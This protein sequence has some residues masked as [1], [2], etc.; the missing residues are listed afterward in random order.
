MSERLIT[1]AVFTTGTQAHMARIALED[2]GIA[3]FIADEN[4]ATVNW[5]WTAAVGGIKLQVIEPDAPRAAEILRAHGQLPPEKA[6][7]AAAVEQAETAGPPCPACG[8]TSS[9]IER[10][11]LPVAL[12]SILLLGFPLLF[13]RRRRVCRKCGRRWR[14]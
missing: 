13:L 14:A 5:L 3:C 1:V 6:S 12:V 11:S 4:V 2:A 8:S 10:F 9:C 7:D